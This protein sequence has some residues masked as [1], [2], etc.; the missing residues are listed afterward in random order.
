MLFHGQCKVKDSE[1]EKP[2]SE[3]GRESLLSCFCEELTRISILLIIIL[4]IV[5]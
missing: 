1:G 5:T 3:F 4:H 2:Y